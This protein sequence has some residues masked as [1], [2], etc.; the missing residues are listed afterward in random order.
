MTGLCSR[1]D[2]LVAS[3]GCFQGDANPSS[4][5]WRRDLGAIL[6]STG[7]RPAPVASEWHLWGTLDPLEASEAAV[8]VRCSWQAGHGAVMNMNRETRT[9]VIIST[10]LIIF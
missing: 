3:A 6:A 4:L 8:T 7:P 5:T 1:Y 2:D 9:K 10:T